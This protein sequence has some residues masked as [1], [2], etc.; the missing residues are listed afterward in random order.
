MDHP[1][2]A[3]D[4]LHAVSAIKN[5]FSEWIRHHGIVADPQ[6]ATVKDPAP[7]ESVVQPAQTQWQRLLTDDVL[8]TN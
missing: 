8:D 6:T 7:A 3:A 4:Y 1:I 5:V 2:R